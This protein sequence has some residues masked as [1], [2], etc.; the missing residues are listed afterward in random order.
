[1]IG[2]DRIPLAA[3]VLTASI[4]VIGSN[5]LV[6]G[7]IAPAVAASLDAKVPAVMMASAVFGLGT[8]ASALFLARYIDRVGARRMLRLAM[9]LLAVALAAC[10]LA[11]VVDALIAAQL[12]AGLASGIALP[13]IYASAAA[14]ATPGREAR[15]IG[16]VLIGW[17]L[18]MVAGV[19]L[20]A[21]LADVI[22]W[23]AV[24]AAVAA[25]ALAATAGLSLMPRRDALAN[26]AAPLPF[27]A[28]RLPGIKPLLV[29]C[30][31]FMASFYGIYGYLGDYVHSALGEPVSANGIFALVYGIGFGAS[32]AL[33]GL[34]DRIGARRLLPL[35]LLAVAF[36]FL[37]LALASSSFVAVVVVIGLWGL[38]NHFGLNL[39]IMRLTAID[40]S[41]RGTIMGLNSA[42][43]YLAVF[44]GTSGFGPIYTGY[45]FRSC[46]IV[47]VALMLV[48]AAAAALAPE[49]AD[50][51]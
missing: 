40:P 9:S 42:V 8:A 27:A 32:A 50:Q 6:L 16:V 14:V 30:A 17:T 11:P 22:H 18:S 10:A 51:R 13:A 36:I 47:A 43:T 49:S 3:Y 2:P 5:S 12:V 44:A 46:A 39:L 23:R 48:A 31:C 34:A 15:T 29:T 25:L 38:A 41:Q 21:V 26:G 45:G 19:S 20:S 1:M 4:G 37:L 24:Y 28:L 33:D 35:A 7:P